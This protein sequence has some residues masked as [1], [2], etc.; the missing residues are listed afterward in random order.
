MDDAKIRPF[1]IAAD[2][3]LAMHFALDPYLYVLQ[4]W[5]LVKSICMRPQNKKNANSGS[6]SVSR[7][8]SMRTTYEVFSQQP[9]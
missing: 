4:H 7:S 8:S 5:T 9:L 6:A 1:Y 3:L 2:M